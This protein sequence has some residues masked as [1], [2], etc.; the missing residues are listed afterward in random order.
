MKIAKSA[1]SKDDGKGNRK[2]KPI[3]SLVPEDDEILD[4]TKVASFK[5]RTIP[6]DA[7]S[8]K[9]SFSMPI[10]DGT[11]SV[12]QAINWYNKSQKL[13][14]GLALADNDAKDNLIKELVK[15]APLAAYT[16]TITSQR[17]LAWANARDAAGN[18][19]LRGA[20]ADEA[21]YQTAVTNARN[22]V[23]Q[24]PLTDLMIDT[25]LGSVIESICPYKALE[26]QK[27]YMRRFMRKPADMLTRTYVNHIIRMNNEEI[28]C[29]PP[30]NNGQ[31]LSVDEIT[32]IVLYGIPKSWT[33]KMDEH[34][35][36]PLAN[37]L[38]ELVSFCER[39]E[40]A[41]QLERGAA[42]H[43]QPSNGKK[44]STK[45]FKPSRNNPDSGSGKWCHYHE[46]DTHDTS[47]CE[48]LKRLKSQQKSGNSS[49]G[50]SKNKTWKR[51]ADDAK[52]YS[53][54]EL[55]AIGKKAAKAAVKKAKAECN[56]V[57]KRKSEED[58]MSV[59]SSSSESINSANVVEKL[60]KVDKELASFDFSED[61]EVS[62]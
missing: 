22:A 28:P 29:L 6:A 9:Y 18:A 42:E 61:G 13:F 26:K 16:A 53:K 49:S 8:A 30:F 45:K 43:K 25:G 31:G 55:S 2:V 36:D 40:S 58:E 37:S 27:R 5:L 35:F 33:H 39:L 50:P 38:E 51:K 14:R 48:T 20:H 1:Y 62:C 60:D 57:A 32:D 15:D 19:I 4:S 11:C 3:L 34:D 7:N 12:R 59:S 46:T 17:A 21:A 24:P 44:S 52:S 23:V 41:E 54:K 56:A 47:E 10:I